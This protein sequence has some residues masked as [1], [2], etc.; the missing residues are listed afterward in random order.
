MESGKRELRE[1]LK[2]VLK[3]LILQEIRRA[4]LGLSSSSSSPP[5]SPPS[6]S[7]PPFVVDEM[8]RS[9]EEAK[10]EVVALVRLMPTRERE[11]LIKG[12]I[13]QSFDE[14][15]DQAIRMRRRRCFRCVHLRYFDEG[16]SPHS[17][18][19]V[20]NERARVVGCEMISCPPG[21]ECQRFVENPLAATVGDYL[22][23]M[24]MLYDVKEMFDHIERIWE[25]YLTK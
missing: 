7:P 19:P 11:R 18:F 12:L 9:I 6:P 5:S 4:R 17:S 20:G 14:E 1:A 8:I 3:G 10:R 24:S 22:M 25:D 21:S 16:G 2:I 15:I 23:G 13:H